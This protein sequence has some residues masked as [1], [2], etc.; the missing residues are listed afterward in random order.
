MLAT[1]SKSCAL[2][3]VSRG[4]FV[5]GEK[6]VLTCGGG[7]AHSSVILEMSRVPRTAEGGRV[8]RI[9]EAAWISL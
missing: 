8:F 9:S 1:V 5:S 4:G 2:M 3:S 7:F 6:E